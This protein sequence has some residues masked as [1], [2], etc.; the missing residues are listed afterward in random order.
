MSAAFVPPRGSAKVTGNSSARKPR[1][2]KPRLRHF[3]ESGHE[4]ARCWHCASQRTALSRTQGSE[5]RA[6]DQAT[7]LWLDTPPVALTVV[8]TGSAVYRVIKHRKQGRV[9]FVIA[10]IIL[11]SLMV[12]PVRTIEFSETKIAARSL[13][14]AMSRLRS[15]RSAAKSEDLSVFLGPAPNKGTFRFHLV[16]S[17]TE[18]ALGLANSILQSDGSGGNGNHPPPVREILGPSACIR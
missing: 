7:E 3:L 1:C 14:C 10:S 2:A 5:N 11:G 18:L 16:A 15:S 13:A 8:F 9:P 6:V 12:V 4:L 17:V